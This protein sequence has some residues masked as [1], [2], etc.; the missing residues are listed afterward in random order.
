MQGLG[1]LAWEM[2]DSLGH[3]IADGPPIGFDE[4]NYADAETEAV[5]I[6]YG[7]DVGD[8]WGIWDNSKPTKQS[9]MDW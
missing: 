4:R 9:G 3:G 2:S 5:P 6:V 7:A 8:W 1:R